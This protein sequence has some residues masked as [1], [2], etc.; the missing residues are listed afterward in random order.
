MNF[1]FSRKSNGQGVQRI[2][3]PAMGAIGGNFFVHGVFEV[4]E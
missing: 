4:D 1:F 3:S 2:L